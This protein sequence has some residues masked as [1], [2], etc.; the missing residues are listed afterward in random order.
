MSDMSDAAA[1]IAEVVGYPIDFTFRDQPMPDGLWS[2]LVDH[3]HFDAS[4]RWHGNSLDREDVETWLA[5]EAGR[6]VER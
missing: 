3:V 4:G 6:E 1:W 5:D 2:A